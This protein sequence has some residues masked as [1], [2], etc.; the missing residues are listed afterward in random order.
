M[1]EKDIM[2]QLAQALFRTTAREISEDV[3][4]VLA[5]G[6][7]KTDLIAEMTKN[8]VAVTSMYATLLA[9]GMK[10][11]GRSEESIKEMV[12]ETVYKSLVAERELH[13][14]LERRGR[15][16]EDGDEDEGTDE[17]SEEEEEYRIVK[18]E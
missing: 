7:G 10:A 18:E 9:F 12:E 3:I 14:E 11:K 1:D 15:K 16:P 17:K 2:D 5:D 8:S 4:D 13:V 6:F